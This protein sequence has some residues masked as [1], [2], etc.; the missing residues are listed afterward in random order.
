MAD[1]KQKD[2][3][4]NINQVPKHIRDVLVG[5]FCRL[6]Y[7]DLK[8]RYKQNDVLNQQKSFDDFN[9]AKEYIKQQIITA[10]KSQDNSLAYTA[11]SQFKKD[12]E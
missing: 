5:S 8:K 1:F 9:R 2:I 10:D 7:K 6:K 12:N 4:Q 11:M 3:S